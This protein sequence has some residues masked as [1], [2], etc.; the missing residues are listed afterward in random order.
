MMRRQLTVLAALLALSGSLQSA[1]AQQNKA[2]TLTANG[3]GPV[4]IGM[5]VAEAGKALGVKLVPA[6]GEKPDPE[7][8][9]FKAAKGY[10]GVLF[11]VQRQRITRADL[12]PDAKSA[13]T[14]QGIRIGDSEK[15]VRQAYGKTLKVTP[16]HYGDK[17][18]YYLTI[19]T[20]PQR[21]RGIRYETMG[22]KVNAIQGGD[23]SIELVE[24]CS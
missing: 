4:Q 1:Q 8:D 3:Y 11:M 10:N 13:Q 21:K 16:H 18:D 23:R 5:T 15:K 12:N 20:T 2:Y 17:G 19:W 9:Y 7:C 14:D 24:G 6:Y 22:G